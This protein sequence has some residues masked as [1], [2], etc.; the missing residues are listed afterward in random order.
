MINREDVK[1]QGGRKNCV[2]RVTTKAGL[3]AGLSASSVSQVLLLLLLLLL[4]VVV[5]V[6]VVVVLVLLLLLLLNFKR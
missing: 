5:V 1:L 3:K 4:L 6:V 2:V